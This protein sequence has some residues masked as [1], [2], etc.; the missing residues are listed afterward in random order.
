[1]KPPLPPAPAVVFN[2][3]A[4]TAIRDLV[5]VT[6]PQLAKAAGLDRSQ[7]WRLEKGHSVP[8]VATLAR[9][10]AALRVPVDAL[11]MISAPAPAG[12]EG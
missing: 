11:L 3:A 8:T 12:D 5:G 10:A 7:L 9:L 1:M 6:A 2:P 4:L